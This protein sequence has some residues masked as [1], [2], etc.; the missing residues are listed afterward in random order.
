MAAAVPASP[1]VKAGEGR[2][3]YCVA[4]DGSE[5]SH[6]GFVVTSK[7]ARPGD[8][9]TVLHIERDGDDGELPFKFRASS[10]RDR[11]ETALAGIATEAHSKVHIQTRSEDDK[12]YEAVICEYFNCDSG[13]SC[14]VTLPP[15]SAPLSRLAYANEEDCDLLVV[16]YSGRK[17][18]KEDPSM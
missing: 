11:Y 9:V 7:L 16:G 8:A 6:Y 13:G 1:V 5:R 15:E 18:I 12:T 10:I 14:S 2:L 3:S 4:V 17:G